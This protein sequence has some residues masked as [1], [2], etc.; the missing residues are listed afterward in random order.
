MIELKSPTANMD[1]MDVK[2]VVCAD[3]KIKANAPIAK[4]DNTRAG[5]IIF[6]R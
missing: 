1:T 6:V 3:I 4:K 5:L 2:P